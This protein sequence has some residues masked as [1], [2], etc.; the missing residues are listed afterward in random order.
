MIDLQRRQREAL[1]NVPKAIPKERLP[2]GADISIATNLLP[3]DLNSTTTAAT[4]TAAADNEPSTSDS[5]LKMETHEHDDISY[6]QV[7][8]TY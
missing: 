3:S 5:A 8:G 4:T 6:P 7:M 1:E 2:P